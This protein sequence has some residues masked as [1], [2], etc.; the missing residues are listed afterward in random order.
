MAKENK[1]SYINSIKDLFDSKL[2]LRRGAAEKTIPLLAL[3]FD[4]FVYLRDEIRGHHEIINHRMS[5]FAATQSLLYGAYATAAASTNVPECFSNRLIPIVGMLLCILMVP[6]V[7][8][9]LE[10]IEVLRIVLKANQTRRH[11]MIYPINSDL[12]HVVA[13]QYPRLTPWVFYLSWVFLFVHSQ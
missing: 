6:S 2:R 3:N 12:W 13:L 8:S 5:W 9:A 1:L 11:K 7:E 4:E 10:R